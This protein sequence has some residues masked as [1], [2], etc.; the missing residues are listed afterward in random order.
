VEDMI[1]RSFSEFNS[2]KLLPEQQQLLMKAEKRLKSLEKISCIYEEPDIENYHR[3]VKEAK[4]YEAKMTD[5]ITHSQKGQSALASGRVILMNTNEYNNCLAVVTKPSSLTQTAIQALVIYDKNK[6]PRNI[7][8][9]TQLQVTKGKD[10]KLIQINPEDVYK[11]TKEKLKVE[12]DKLFNDG[13]VSSLAQQLIRITEEMPM[14]PAELD[15]IKELKINDLDFGESLMRRNNVLDKM[16]KSKCH[17]CPKLV[18]QFSLMDTHS[19]LKEKVTGLKFALSDENLFLMPEFQQRLVVLERLKYI[20]VDKTV[21]LKGRVA[22][23]VDKQTIF[24]IF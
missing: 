9:N 13:Y 7:R 14:G 19:T 3:L 21:L 2:Q 8:L 5:F 12:T 24:T 11:I 22:R 6:T 18:E 15:P 20:D 1:K 23:E 4:N 10:Y 16:T 17:Q